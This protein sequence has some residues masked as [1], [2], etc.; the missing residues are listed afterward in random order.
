MLT[1]REIR[2]FHGLPS[3]VEQNPRLEQLLTLFLPRVTGG[4]P[5]RLCL[6][7]EF[8]EFQGKIDGLQ[9]DFSKCCN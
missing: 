7:G 2:L 9:K 3:E 6:P 8:H 1:P 4:V 5:F